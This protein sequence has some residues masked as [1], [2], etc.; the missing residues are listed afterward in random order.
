MFEKFNEDFGKE[1]RKKER[2]INFGGASILRIV[3]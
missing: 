3:I 1:L 2:G